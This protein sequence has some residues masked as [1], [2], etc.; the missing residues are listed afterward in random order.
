MCIVRVGFARGVRSLF[1]LPLSSLSIP[2]FVCSIFEH[3]VAGAV[4]PSARPG[5]LVTC[6][7]R[8]QWSARSPTLRCRHGVG[9]GLARPRGA[10]ILRSAGLSSGG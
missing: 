7:S 3:P 1:P 2:P 5:A 4:A 8:E 6:I 9:D 10:Q